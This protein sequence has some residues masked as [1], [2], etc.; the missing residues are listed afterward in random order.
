M[1]LPSRLIPLLERFGFTVERL[2][3][4]MVAPRDDERG[5]Q[6]GKGGIHDRRGV[7]LGTAA[8]VLDGG[9]LDRIGRSRRDPENCFIDIGFWV[10]HKT[11]RNA[12][13]ITVQLTT[14]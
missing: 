11:A 3:N 6:D 9:A 8:A 2:V 12:F 1:T 14:I 13:R 10:N 4:R 7:F 5:R